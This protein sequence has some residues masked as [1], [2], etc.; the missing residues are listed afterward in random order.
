MK[1]TKCR[2]RVKFRRLEK[3][4]EV[5]HLRQI[6]LV[7]EAAL[8]SSLPVYVSSRR[9]FRGP[10]VSFGPAIPQGYESDTEI[11]DFYFEKPVRP[12]SCAEIYRP[13]EEH[14]FAF[15]SAKSVPVLFPSADSSVQAMEHDV[16]FEGASLS[17]AV[18]ERNFKKENMVYRREKKG[19]IRKFDA[20]PFFLKAA[21]REEA[22]AVRMIFRYSGGVS[23]RPEKVLESVF[24]NELKISKVVRTRLYWFDS[25]GRYRE[26]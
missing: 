4:R 12:A 26:I 13:L 21:L 6:R 8:K 15:A 18:F 2:I 14:G 1:N 22:G 19:E 5:S 23:V 25:Q 16:F 17:E 9:G 20:S 3:A 24:K 11:A 10:R 7:R